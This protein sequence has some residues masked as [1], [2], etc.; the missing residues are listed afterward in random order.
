MGRYCY[1]N[2]PN[3]LMWNMACFASTLVPLLEGT[4]EKKVD[5]L[6]KEISSIPEKYK[7]KWCN[8]ETN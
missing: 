3:I 2:Q 6:Q 1:K 7:N 8:K 5:I 4:E